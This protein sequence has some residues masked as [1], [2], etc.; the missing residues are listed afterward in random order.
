MSWLQYFHK[1]WKRILNGSSQ[2]QIIQNIFWK[3]KNVDKLLFGF[4]FID[5]NLSVH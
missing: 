4:W 5:S 2:K 1:I 3:K